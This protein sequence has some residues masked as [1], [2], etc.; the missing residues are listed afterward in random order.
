M[1]TNTTSILFL[2]GLL[3]LLGCGSAGT[4]VGSAPDDADVT[5]RDGGA[6]D[7]GDIDAGDTDGGDGDASDTNGGD[8][9]AG[10]PPP[11]PC[12][13]TRV[14]ENLAERLARMRPELA[15]PLE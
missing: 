6:T 4:G 8:V 9:D 5:E 2:C 3:L 15:E 1:R 14:R 10:P 13:T 7:A 12:S 11:P